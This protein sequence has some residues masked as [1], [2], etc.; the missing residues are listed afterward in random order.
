MDAFTIIMLLIGAGTLTHWF[1]R[2][3]DKLEGRR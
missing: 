1:M 3:L 2:L